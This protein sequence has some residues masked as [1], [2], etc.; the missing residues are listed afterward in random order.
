MFLGVF[1]HFSPWNILNY[2]KHV[3]IECKIIFLLCQLFDAPS[4]LIKDSD[5]VINYAKNNN[6]VCLISGAGSTLLLISNCS[7]LSNCSSTT[8]VSTTSFTGSSFSS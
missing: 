5:V 2:E 1:F 8:S 6:A 3:F 4:V 7:T